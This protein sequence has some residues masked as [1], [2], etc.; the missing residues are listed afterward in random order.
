MAL[1]ALA[2]IAAG[3]T[4]WIDQ[5]TQDHLYWWQSFLQT[6]KPR[7]VDATPPDSAPALLF[8]DGSEEGNGNHVGIGDMLLDGQTK[9]AF[10]TNMLTTEVLKWKE[11]SAKTALYIKRSLPRWK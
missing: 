6:T 11:A 8:V 3:K 7:V 2:Y 4:D 9:E 10:G 1:T 5:A